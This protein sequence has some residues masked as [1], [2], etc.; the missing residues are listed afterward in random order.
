MGKTN[1]NHVPQ[2]LAPE[3]AVRVRCPNVLLERDSE[4]V[5]PQESKE[6]SRDIDSRRCPG[7]VD[8][9]RNMAETAC[10]EPVVDQIAVYDRPPGEGISKV[11]GGI[12]DY[13]GESWIGGHVRVVDTNSYARERDQTGQVLLNLGLIDGRFQS[14]TLCLFDSCPIVNDEQLDVVVL[15]VV[16]WVELVRRKKIVDGTIDIGADELAHPELPIVIARVDPSELRCDL[17]GEL[18][19]PVAGSG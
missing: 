9:I 17:H 16:D 3:S 2:R 1:Q 12:G 5:V 11:R 19:R 8:E 10:C 15:R 4:R 18:V 6:E 7:Y 13:R 14:G